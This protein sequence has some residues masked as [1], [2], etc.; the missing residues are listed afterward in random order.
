VGTIFRIGQEL[1]TNVV[2]HAKATRVD[3]FLRYADGQITLAVQDNGRGSKLNVPKRG[4]GL[5]GIQER[6]ELLGGGIEIRSERRMGT[7]VVVTIPIDPQ[8][9][10]F[11]LEY[12]VTAEQQK[13]R[14]H[15][16]KV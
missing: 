1:I 2:R 5:R 3:V 16:K 11:P 8:W 4:Y 15:E 10:H 9:S 12:Q 6:A 14:R 13:R 7:T